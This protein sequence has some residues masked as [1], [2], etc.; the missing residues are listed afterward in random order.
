MK[1]SILLILLI[2][3]VVALYAGKA[4]AQLVVPSSKAAPSVIVKFSWRYTEDPYGDNF[5]TTPGLESQDCDLCEWRAFIWHGQLHITRVNREGEG[6][7]SLSR[8]DT[9]YL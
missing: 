6:V 8:T 7:T 3:F 5:N 1:P 2:A 9:D 4:S